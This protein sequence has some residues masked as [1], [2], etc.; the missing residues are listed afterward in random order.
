V[1]DATV[2]IKGLPELQKALGTS[3]ETMSFA[4]RSGLTRGAAFVQ[5]DAKHRVP[6]V[7]HKLESAIVIGKVEGRGTEKQIRIG[8]G[9]GRGSGSRGRS[10]RAGTVSATNPTRR[11]NTSDP[12]EYGPY[13]E[14]G[15]RPH[16]IVPRRGK[17]L[18]FPVAV[19]GPLKPMKRG[20]NKGTSKAGVMTNTV[21]VRSVDHPGTHPH[22]F[23]VSA[24]NENRAVITRIVEDRILE[25]I[26][27]IVKHK[28][29]P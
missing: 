6:K 5:K 16:K 7:T 13:V 17:A 25:V 11:K 15:T 29:T 28:A 22:P 19:A 14:F 2:V 12:Q 18:A 8:V 3:N 27:D 1:P 10:V 20:K 21:V 4:I 24:L 23:L 26:K 9:P